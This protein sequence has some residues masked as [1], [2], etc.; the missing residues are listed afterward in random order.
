MAKGLS[1]MGLN[2]LS[3][4]TN[5]DIMGYGYTAFTM[6]SKTQTRSSS[7]ASYLRE[8]LAQTANLNIYKNT[9]AKKILFDSQKRATGVIVDSG[10]VSY[11]L[12]ATKEVIVSAGVFRSP[13]LLMVSG[14]GAK[15]TL[16]DLNIPLIADLPG[17][18]QICG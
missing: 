6:D 2:E 8:A 10:G 3:G 5:G 7:E 14:I 16:T 9:I 18:G 13:Q 1:E 15:Q 17:V 12:N 11:Q 4:L